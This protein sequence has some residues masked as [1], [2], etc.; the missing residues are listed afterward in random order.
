[1]PNDFQDFTS[2][3]DQN[4]NPDDELP[5]LG[6]SGAANF[7]SNSFSPQGLTT[8]Q[9]GTT[10]MIND[11]VT[12]TGDPTL[13]NMPVNDETPSL[14]FVPQPVPTAIPAQQPAKVEPSVFNIVPMDQ[15]LNGQIQP[16][17]IEPKP[18]VP[19]S[20]TP[21]PEPV[22]VGYQ[23]TPPPMPSETISQSKMEGADNEI[24][25][26]GGLTSPTP[27]LT[28]Q[29]NNGSRVNY[30]KVLKN[31]S[32]T[33]V[34]KKP[35]NAPIGNAFLVIKDMQGTM[36]KV[37][38]T[39]STGVFATLLRAPFAYNLEVKHENDIFEPITLN[40]VSTADYSFEVSSLN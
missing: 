10:P 34:V 31:A 12:S 39:D 1:M 5:T 22:A 21:R 13:N 38:V 6:A 29:S 19:S 33:G 20:A 32:V 8:Y 16:T 14:G 26:L 23:F 27:E 15:A 2:T 4:T 17:V 3:N 18:V 30:S 24:P 25:T 28:I 7:G 40:L 11:P 36:V 35:T 9:I 37:L